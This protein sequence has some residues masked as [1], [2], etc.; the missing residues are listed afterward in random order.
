MDYNKDYPEND[1]ESSVLD[2]T[3]LQATFLKK[4]AF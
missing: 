1:R 4:S 2:S 3:Q